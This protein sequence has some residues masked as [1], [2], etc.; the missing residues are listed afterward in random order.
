M[1][2]LTNQLTFRRL[3]HRCR[4]EDDEAGAAL[5]IFAVAL[6][7]LMAFAAMAVDLGNISQTKGH[8][9]TAVQ[10]AVLSALPNLK[11][12]YVGNPFAPPYLTQEGYAVTAAETYLR[13]NY[14]SLSPTDNSIFNTCSQLLPLATTLYVVPNADCFGFFDPADPTNLPLDLSNPTGMAVAFPQQTVNYTLGKAV[15]LK[16]QAVSSVA[17]ASIKTAGNFGLPFGYVSGGQTG[18]VCIKTKSSG[19]TTNNCVGGGFTTST[20]TY[21]LLNSPRYTIYPGNNTAAGI[22]TVVE[23][24]MAIGIDHHLTCS[25]SSTCTTP[26]ASEICDAAGSWPTCNA[27]GYNNVA[28]YDNGNYAAPQTGSTTNM[29]APA[30]FNGGF[31]APDGSGCPIPPRFSQPDGF[32]ATGTCST[33]T[34]AAAAG[35]SGPYL[36][37]SNPTP[38]V[39]NGSPSKLNGRHIS[40][41][42]NSTGTSAT[43]ACASPGANTVA[44]D[45]MSGSTYAW[46]TYDTCLWPALTANT[47]T[48]PVFKSS[49]EQ[50]PRFG[51]VPQLIP[52]SGSNPEQITGFYGV[53]LDLATVDSSQ[54]KVIALQAWVFPL[55]MIDPT[56][57]SGGGGSIY[58][59]GPWVA[60]LC[61]FVA[62]YN[63]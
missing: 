56:P 24:D 34:N 40:Y 63:C 53:Y 9:E 23:T 20:G 8:T 37:P 36:N 60:N 50:S 32:T 5:V 57:G 4:D 29:L 55:S 28:P 15:G 39:P 6:A 22:N 27:Y 25:S 46:A 12:L 1:Q 7:G 43:S 11:S 38:D 33:D 31:T 13:D 16:S 48:G 62:A 52:S 26:P 51:I 41:Y 17:F 47:V 42:L 45:A 30:L 58:T 61:S 44:I 2:R 49:I 3:T 21:G 10:D 54:T 35:P 19:R 14:S 59:G 18:L